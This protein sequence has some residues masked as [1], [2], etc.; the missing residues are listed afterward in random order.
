MAAGS[1]CREDGCPQA[2]AQSQCYQ[3]GNGHLEHE[4]GTRAAATRL[5]YY[6]TGKH[7]PLRS[8][9]TRVISEMLGVRTM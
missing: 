9:S 8:A 7:G 3:G 5:D 1:T 2:Y 4:I 6:F